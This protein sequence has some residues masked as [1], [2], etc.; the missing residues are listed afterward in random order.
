M[1]RFVNIVSGMA[2]AALAAGGLVPTAS[3]QGDRSIPPQATYADLA[4]LADSAPLVV[5]AKI[6]RQA[7]VEAERAPGLQAG[8]T[9]LYVE[10]ETVSLLAGNV[11]IG[12]SLRYLV[13]VPR[14]DRG[15]APKLKKQEVILFA[16]PVPNRPG[17]LQLAEPR[18][19]L[20]WSEATE[21]RLRPVLAGLHAA[22]AL[23]AVTG[24]RDALSVAGNL[25]GESETQVFLLTQDDSPLALTVVRRPGMA[26]VWGFSRSEIVD[27]SVLAPRP[28]TIAWYR[29]ACFLP[30][31]LP[32]GAN[33]AT[34][35][36]AQ[37]QA[38]VDYLFVLSE[39]G[40][41]P[42]NRN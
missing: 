14:D 10:A 39:L 8:F 32:A 2:A 12:G 42:R 9:R 18:A 22:D 40:P 16:R 11:P 23:P 5:R 15:R 7:E 17:E 41:C 24:I 28:D 30:P 31:S 36:A 19:Q 1:K 4:D 35:S 20:P 27:Q 21:Q 13:D 6:K 3:A 33:L 25:A 29:L 38:V 34:D 37:Q 26:P